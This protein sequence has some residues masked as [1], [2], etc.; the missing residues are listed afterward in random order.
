MMKKKSVDPRLLYDIL[1]GLKVLCAKMGPRTSKSYIDTNSVLKT[2][3][4][5]S[6]KILNLT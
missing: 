1:Q 5:T 3:K 6:E 4:L 2:C